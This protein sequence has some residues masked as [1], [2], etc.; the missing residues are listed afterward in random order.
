MAKARKGERPDFTAVLMDKLMDSVGS[1]DPLAHMGTSVV[2]GLPLQAFSL[3]YLFGLDVLPVGKSI[4]LV[5][6]PET[7][8]SFFT[9]EIGR[10][11]VYGQTDLAEF[12]PTIH[13]G[14][15]V[16]N[17][18]EP[19]RDQNDLRNSVIQHTIEGDR[20]IVF[21]QHKVIED[22]QTVCTRICQSFNDMTY[23]NGKKIEI[24]DVDFP[25]CMAVDS[26]SGLTT[27]KEFDDVSEEGHADPGFANAAKSI[28]QYFKILPS[29]MQGWPITFVVTNHLKPGKSP[30][31]AI[32]EQIP[33]GYAPHFNDSLRLRMRRVRDKEGG[34]V[35]LNRATGR[36]LWIE[37]MKNSMTSSGSQR[38]LRVQVLWTFDDQDR[39]KSVWQWHDATINL[40]TVGLDKTTKDEI[41]DLVDL[42]I[43]QT[44]R[45]VTSDRLK[46]KKVSWDEGGRAIMRDPEI[47]AGLQRIFMVRRQVQW[48]PGVSYRTQLQEARQRAFELEELR[49]AEI[50][51]SRSAT[52][53]T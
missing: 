27:R 6:I 16:Y 4:E 24:G 43:N 48:R 23:D 9:H 20:V 50:R 3:Q 53:E 37:T 26:L 44:T 41:D 28:N 35:D 51:S 18:A 40:L 36:E 15:Y 33:G 32:T 8:K 52:K 25:L 34:Y 14:R 46:L 38:Q 11:H 30:T 21:D 19:N 2:V 47:V 45:T 31:G 29:M 13:V 39:Q 7:C 17:L 5:G 49:M 10:W 1:K 42:E 22:W 12:D